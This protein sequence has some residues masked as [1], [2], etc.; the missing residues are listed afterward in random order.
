MPWRGRPRGDF[1]AETRGEA[2]RFQRGLPVVRR[3]VELARPCVRAC[4]EGVG[5][6]GSWP[7]G[8]VEVQD[9]GRPGREAAQTIVTGVVKH[10]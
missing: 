4:A 5:L 10:D 8:C 3:D 6:V 1:R 9:A 2:R 7:E